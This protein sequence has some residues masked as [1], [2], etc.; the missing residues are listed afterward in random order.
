MN[1]FFCDKCG[2]CCKNIKGIKELKEFDRGD[3]ICKYLNEKT[4]LCEIYENRPL[5]CRVD[6][7]YE[8]YFYKFYSK[9]EYYQ[10]NY[11]A[12]K[13]LKGEI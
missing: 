3:G 12:C 9:E 1:N 7:M 10:L 13:K 5:I 4:N 8:K 2:L 11:N 6:E